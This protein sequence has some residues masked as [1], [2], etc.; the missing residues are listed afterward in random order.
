MWKAGKGEVGDAVKVRHARALLVVLK[1]GVG[2]TGSGVQTYRWSLGLPGEQPR[3]FSMWS[4]VSQN[5]EEVGKALKESSVPRDQLWL[6]SK[7]RLVPLA[8]YH[9]LILTAMEHIPRAGRCRTRPRRL[10]IQAPSQLPRFVPH[11]LAHC[12]QKG[13]TTQVRQGSNRGPLPDLEKAGRAR[14]EGQD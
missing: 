8:I 1:D 6:T 10:T 9:L 12:V 14:R 4:N 13:R 3:L 7:V 2:C 11:P 5:E